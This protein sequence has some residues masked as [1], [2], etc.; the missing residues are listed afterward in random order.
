VT[1]AAFSQGKILFGNDSL[2]LV[3][4]AITWGDDAA[5]TGQAV[6][7][8]HM[9]NGITLVADLYVG[10]SSSVLSYVSSAAFGTAPGKF[11]A[12]PVQ[13]AGIPGGTSVFVVTQI[14]DE[15]VTPSPLFYG[16]FIEGAWAYSQ[17]FTFTLGSGITYPSMW[18][19]DGTWP[20][21]TYALD[22]Y[23]YGAGARG[24]IGIYEIPEPMTHCLAVL[25][26]VL[27][28]AF[29]RVGWQRRTDRKKLALG[30]TLFLLGFGAFAQ[31]KISFQ[32]DSLHLAYYLDRYPALEG[33]AVDSAHMPSGITL[34]ADL[35]VGTS[36]SM[37]S[38]V[39]SATFSAVPGKW[40][41]MSVI[42]PGRRHVRLCRDANS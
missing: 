27:A 32:T 39:S 41:P 25:G 38:F 13:V 33:Q 15:A 17:E 3:Y 21:G 7:S 11:N 28:T 8:A 4:Y 35:Y 2:H 18:G 14:R 6:D 19:A 26:V 22:Q 1:T 37:L 9:P 10:T 29:A 31:G 24:A 16:Q 20:V 36:S 12:L 42:V 30:L 5:L 23:S 40:N 34:V